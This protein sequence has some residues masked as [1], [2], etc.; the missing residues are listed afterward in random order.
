MIKSQNRL[1]AFFDFHSSDFI[2]IA[3]KLAMLTACREFKSCHQS[4]K[5]VKLSRSHLVFESASQFHDTH[6]LPQLRH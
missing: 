1:K 5:T 2:V 6:G 3:Q 4:I